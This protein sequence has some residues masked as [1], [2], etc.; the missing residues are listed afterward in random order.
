MRP[1]R[2]KWTPEDADNWTC[3]DTL[4]VIISPIVYVLL[5]IG[6]ALSIFLVPAGFI[7]LAAG[8]ILL[9]VMVYVI[10]P[11]LDAISEGYEKQQKEYIEE[12]ERKVKWE[13]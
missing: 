12:L 13:D 9:I 5:L 3:E 6:V 11:K 10:E 4:T 1:I 2:R 8:I 7:M